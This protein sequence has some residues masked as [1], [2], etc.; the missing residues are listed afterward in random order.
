[1]GVSLNDAKLLTRISAG[2]VPF[3]KL[4]T[5]GRQQ[6]YFRPADLEA[7]L[8]SS[9]VSAEKI[10]RFLA[11]AKNQGSADPFFRALGAAEIT[12]LDYSDYQGA[13]IQ[14]DLNAPVDPKLHDRFDVVFDGGTIEHVFNF[15][16]AIG[17][18]MEMVR[19]G[20][21]LISVTPANNQMGHGFYQFSP[22]LF[23]N[24]LS[25]ENGYRVASMIALELSP[26][27]RWYSVENPAVIRSRVTLTNLWGVNLF[28]HAV[29]EAKT[30]LFRSNPLQSDYAALWKEGVANPALETS[31]VSE[32]TA[33]SSARNF[34]KRWFPLPLYA[35]TSIRLLLLSSAFGFRNSKFFKRVVG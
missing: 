2:G 10:A 6:L 32:S 8:R 21:S 3:G 5:L 23:Y 29:R 15:P 4:L 34:V 27:N 35:M 17:N 12:S 1:M 11:E 9:G 22:E 28:V 20:G 33:G 25:K 13:S 7:T 14:H 30:P 24:V 19:V 16:V 26:A 18:A 31:A